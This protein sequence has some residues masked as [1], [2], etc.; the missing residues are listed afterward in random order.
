MKSSISLKKI[1]ILT[2]RAAALNCF[3]S[4]SIDRCKFL[5]KAIKMAQRD[6]WDDECKRVF[7]DLKKYLTSP[8]LLSK[9]EETK[10]LYIYLAVLE[11]AVSS[12][13]MREELRAHLLVF[14]TFKALLDEK[15]R[16]LKIK[17]LILALVVAARKLRP[18]F[19]AHIIIVMTQYLL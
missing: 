6:K 13:F 9:P 8:P 5:F 4:Q 7:Q 11:V 18:Y 16:Y 14:Y 15:T 1:Q 2:R 19:Q 10:D 12:A 17:K 3:L